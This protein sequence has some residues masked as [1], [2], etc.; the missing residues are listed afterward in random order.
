MKGVERLLYLVLV[1]VFVAAGI[2]FT[3]LLVLSHQIKDSN[4]RQTRYIQCL[5]AAHGESQF[6]GTGVEN[7]CAKMANNV[8]LED[9]TKP[10]NS[11]IQTTTSSTNDT[12]NPTPPTPPQRSFISPAIDVINKVLK[13][14]SL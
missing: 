2:A 12:Q 1:L 11:D 3:A 10:Q 6:V 4:D 13:G 9:V 8:T 14:V 7:Q 5:L